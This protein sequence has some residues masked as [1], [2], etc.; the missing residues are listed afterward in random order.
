MKKLI[1][2]FALLVL[3]A[4]YHNVSPAM[5]L[6]ETTLKVQNDAFNDM[7]IY[8]IRGSETT[9]LGTANGNTTTLL[10]IPGRVLS[11]PTSLRFQARPIAGRRQPVTEEITVTAGDEVTMII[12]HA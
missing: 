2:A 12:P 10:K 3:G 11:G 4:C 6:P 9:R 7:N 5:N 1:A 8:L